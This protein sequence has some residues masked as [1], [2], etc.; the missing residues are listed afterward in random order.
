MIKNNWKL[1]QRKNVSRLPPRRGGR[2][3]KEKKSQIDEGP[4]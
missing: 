1:H 4:T 2:H 3:A